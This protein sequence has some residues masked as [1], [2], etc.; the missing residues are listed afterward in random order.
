MM[1]PQKENIK[2]IVPDGKIWYLFNKK[3]PTV[4]AYM[5]YTEND[6]KDEILNLVYEHA[7]KS[8]S[9]GDY[10]IKI[11]DRFGVA[12][13][14]F[15]DFPGR[16]QYANKIYRVKTEWIIFPDG[17]IKANTLIGGIDK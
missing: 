16:N 11:I 4:L 1:A 15:Y 13:T 7:R 10:K 12:I 3:L 2:L 9:L 6:S 14:L 17:K 8:F 5:G